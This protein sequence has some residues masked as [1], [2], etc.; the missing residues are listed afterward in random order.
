MVADEARIIVV[1][2]P[3]GPVVE[4]QTKDRHVVGIHHAVRPSDRLP[5]GDEPGGSLDHFGEETRVFIVGFPK[6][7]EMTVD[8][9]ICEQPQ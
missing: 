4:R 5:S 6:G 7:S 3:E 2:E 1:H 9:E 8:D